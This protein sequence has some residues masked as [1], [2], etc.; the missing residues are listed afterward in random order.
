MMAIMVTM[1]MTVTMATMVTRT[2]ETKRERIISTFLLALAVPC[3]A[4]LGVIFAILSDH[5]KALFVW[6]IVIIMNFILI[7][8]LVSKILPG[9]KPS[10]YIELPP[11]RLPKISNVLTKTYTRMVWY[12]K[13]IFPLFM[14]A[15]FLIWILNLFGLFEIIINALE[16]V[17]NSIG[18]PD[19]T[20]SV[21]FFGFFRRDYGAA[22]LFEIQNALTGVQLTVAAVTLT[23][24]VPCVAQFM[25]MIKER[26]MKTA[27]SMFIF[28]LF[29]AFAVG[30]IL[31]KILI[32][33]G[34][35]L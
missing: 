26:G 15:S 13:E 6:F 23:L 2:Q 34:V 25:I 18:L 29:Y 9:D 11:L 35:T 28:V 20:S 24:F 31:N 8:F 5:P 7:G 27:I 3:S 4:Q 21:F 33:S 19:D 16:P 17:V 10:F 22:G 1:V 12:F 32:T 30:Y 14:L